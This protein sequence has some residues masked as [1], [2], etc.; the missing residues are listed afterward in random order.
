M[1]QKDEGGEGR[2]AA[3]QDL[4]S[5]EVTVKELM[6]RPDAL[7]TAGDDTLMVESDTCRQPRRGQLCRCE[8][9]VEPGVI[10]KKKGELEE[11]KADGRGAG[12]SSQGFRK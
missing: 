10:E 7:R 2:V 9:K 8:Q 5:A 11:A 4:V 12:T 3:E 1:V 6:L